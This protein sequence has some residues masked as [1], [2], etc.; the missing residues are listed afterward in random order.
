M[1]VRICLLV[2]VQDL[3]TSSQPIQVP[4]K[5]SILSLRCSYAGPNSGRFNTDF[6][7][8]KKDNEREKKKN[9]NV[10]EHD[11]QLRYIN[12]TII[13][14]S[15]EMEKPRQIF[16][17][18]LSEKIFDETK[19]SIKIGFWKDAVYLGKFDI[20]LS[21]AAT[22]CCWLAGFQHAV[23]GA[24]MSGKTTFIRNWLMFFTTIQRKRG[25]NIY[26]WFWRCFVW[27]QRFA[28]GLRLF[29]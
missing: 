1:A 25:A 27:L 24:A 28:F 11:T 3:N 8:S 21:V 23:F 26:S 29:R 17:P 16:L 6:Y 7:S 12:N 20:P 13:E 18:P 15:R 4:I 19:W 5:T 2:Q 9:E 14:M 10:N 22:I